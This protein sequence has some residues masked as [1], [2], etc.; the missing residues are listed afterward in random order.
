M[1]RPYLWERMDE[2]FSKTNLKQQYTLD[3]MDWTIPP[4]KQS[5]IPKYDHNQRYILIFDWLLLGR[6]TTQ[7]RDQRSLFRFFA[8]AEWKQPAWQTIGWSEKDDHPGSRNCWTRKRLCWKHDRHQGLCCQSCQIWTPMIS[9]RNPSNR[10]GHS[11]GALCSGNIEKFHGFSLNIVKLYS[12]HSSRQ[13]VAIPK[14]GCFS[15][16]EVWLLGPIMT[17][18]QSWYG[19]SHHYSQ[20]MQ[21]KQH[22][23]SVPLDHATYKPW[24]CSSKDV[25][26]DKYHTSTC[27]HFYFPDLPRPSYTQKELFK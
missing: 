8:L 7:T 13:H 20:H 4:L 19:W 18:C 21:K 27:W 16:F 10:S 14:L 11:L 25:D 5:K 9:K 26:T 15:C 24:S 22:G 3:G 12:S 1:G 6:G 17:P 23:L 2:W